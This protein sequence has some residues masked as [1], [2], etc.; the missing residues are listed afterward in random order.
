MPLR[1][2]HRRGPLRR[3]AWV[4]GL[5]LAGA[6]A[7][8]TSSTPPMPSTARLFYSGHSLTDRPLPDHVEHIA[9]SLGTQVLW[10]RQY[11]VGSSIRRRVQGDDASATDWRGYRQ[12]YNR[13]TE[14]MDVVAE[15]KSARTTDGRPYDVLVITEQHGLLG[16]LIWN[17]TVRYLRHYH[18][19]FIDGNPAGQ[20]FFYE[21][22]I[23][24]NDK[25]DPR[26]WIAYER[27]A[28]P[29]W[30][31]IAERVNLSLAAQG[32][33]DRITPLPMGLALAEL[34]EH[35]LAP[36]ATT[37][38]LKAGTTMDTVSQF[39]GD[40]VHLGP[41]G[42]YYAALV[43]YAASFRRSPVGAW[44]PEG[45][46][47]D[48]ARVLQDFAWA[49]VSN[50]YRDL[51]PRT[52]EDCRDLI[53]SDFAWRYWSYIRDVYWRREMNGAMAYLKWVRHYVEWRYRLSRKDE[54]NPFHHDPA[55]DAAYWL[56]STP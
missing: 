9:R 1:R 28:S 22:W 47:P 44:A 17:D 13:D 51:R 46:R 37:A 10:N 53:R 34:I 16:S 5:C 19:R 25:S 6:C 43:T 52:M 40:E 2:T 21:S 35:S 42:S 23:S 27:T 3:A 36:S 33:R 4:I 48:Q 7:A 20:T 24:L 18:D 54:R 55:T 26:R 50:Y 41:M 56:D 30:H 45:I 38:A 11:V 29:I 14:G 15:F 8:S 39:I 31:C 12:G 49:F 32:R